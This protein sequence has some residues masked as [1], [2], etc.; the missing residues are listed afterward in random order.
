MPEY[1]R[2]MKYKDKET[3][4][5]KG[6]TLQYRGDIKVRHIMQLFIF[7]LYTELRV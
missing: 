1:E 2:Q 6:K 4:E 5:H 3:G 7:T